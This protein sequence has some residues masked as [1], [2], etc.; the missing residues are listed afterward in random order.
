MILD[1]NYDAVRDAIELEFFER[2]WPLAVHECR[3]SDV[4]VI[5]I[6]YG[7]KPPSLFI[8]TDEF[9]LPRDIVFL[10]ARLYHLYQLFH[11][12]HVNNP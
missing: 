11:P 10:R 9:I 5:G 8:L 1:R 6:G 2:E 12:R 4:P 3:L 7:H